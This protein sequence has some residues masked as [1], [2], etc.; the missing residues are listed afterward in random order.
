MCQVLCGKL[1]FF[2]HECIESAFQGGSDGAERWQRGGEAWSQKAVVGSGK[3]ER[4]APA[5]VGDVIS[6]AVGRAV[7]QAV[8]AKPAQ[9]VGHGALGDRRRISA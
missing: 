2:Y 5:E 7:D 3:E 4:D 1:G 9:L 8:K 6:E